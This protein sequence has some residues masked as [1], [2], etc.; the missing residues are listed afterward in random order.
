MALLSG[1]SHCGSY[2][3][4]LQIT[5]NTLVK[6]LLSKPK[7]TN[8]NVVYH[9]LHVGIFNLPIT[10]IEQYIKKSNDTR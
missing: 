1:I 3:N 6:F 10:T 8:Y 2:K 5:V 4:T 9:E 7:F